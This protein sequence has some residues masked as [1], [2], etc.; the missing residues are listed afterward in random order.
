M[1]FSK[2]TRPFLN[3]SKFSPFRILS[4]PWC[5]NAL[6]VGIITTALGLSAATVDLISRNL[7]AANSVDNTDYVTT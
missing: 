2:F 5:F 1:C 7:Y 6:A 4:P 3:V